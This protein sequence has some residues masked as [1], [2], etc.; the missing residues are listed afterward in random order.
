MIGEIKEL[1][2]CA[3]C[4]HIKGTHTDNY[5]FEIAGACT[6]CYVPSSGFFGESYWK[7]KDFVS[8]RSFTHK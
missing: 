7:C 1:E 5:K 3:S 4:G 2:I 8:S 6:M